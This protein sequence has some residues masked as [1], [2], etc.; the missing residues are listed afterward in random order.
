MT[1]RHVSGVI[2]LEGDCGVEHAEVLLQALAGAPGALV[3]WSACARLHTA[4]VQ[5]M[6]ATQIPVRGRCG[7]PWLQRWAPTMVRQ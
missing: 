7:D 1:V 4:V 6:V 5:V 2:F 3:D